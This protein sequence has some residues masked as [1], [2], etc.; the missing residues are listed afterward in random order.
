MIFADEPTANLDLQGIEILKNK[1]LKTETIVL[2][3][4]DRD[5][6]DSIC[7]KII[8]VEDGKLTFFEGNY[9]FY[10]QQK[11]KM[12]DREWFEYKYYID[13]KG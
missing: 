7:N 1:L 9:S 3:S 13:E 5:L 10:K 2:I 4:H 8:E 12:I 11:Q 6:L